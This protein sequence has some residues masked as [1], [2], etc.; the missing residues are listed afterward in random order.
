MKNKHNEDKLSELRE[1]EA[2]SKNYGIEAFT[3]LNLLL[4]FNVQ[5]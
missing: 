4:M 5:H 1:A 2:R 3:L